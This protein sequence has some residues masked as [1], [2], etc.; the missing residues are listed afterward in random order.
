MKAAVSDSENS[1]DDMPQPKQNFQ[2]K[3]AIKK[4]SSPI[5]EESESQIST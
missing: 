1:D 2:K 4:H 3:C 5:A